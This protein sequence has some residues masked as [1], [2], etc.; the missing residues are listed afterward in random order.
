M[1]EQTGYTGTN[2]VPYNYAEIGGNFKC[3]L[4]MESEC[5]P[6]GSYR[7]WIRRKAVK[8]DMTAHAFFLAQAQL[9]QETGVENFVSSAIL[10]R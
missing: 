7:N 2:G 8:K 3:Y 1:E 10:P 5:Y 6:D 9:A 4:R